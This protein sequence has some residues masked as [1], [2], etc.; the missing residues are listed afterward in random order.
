MP[1]TNPA[2]EQP[3][4]GS[5]SDTSTRSPGDASRR[6]SGDPSSGP[7]GDPSQPTGDTSRPAR[8][9]RDTSRPAAA[10]DDASRDA[11]ED[12]D[13]TDDQVEPAD[14]SPEYVARLRREA[15]EHRRARRAAEAERDELR[16]YRLRIELDRHAA[17]RLADVED[18]M[19]F[20]D[21]AELLDP[22]GRPD[23]ARI[24]AAVD[25]LLAEKPYLAPQ[26]R[27]RTGT[28]DGGSRGTPV[29]PRP[30]TI[31]GLLG[32]AARGREG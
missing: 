31:G 2:P 25:A 23:P 6:T 8:A 15:A 9:R 26:P 5:A 16:A 32:R 30:V 11:G 1:T 24:T 13:A 7:A 3:S 27:R 17:P 18:L 14:L 20:R 28:G 12:P 19:T 22:E 10:T 29:E 21:P 4:P